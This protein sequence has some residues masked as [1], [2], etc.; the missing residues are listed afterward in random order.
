MN[1]IM[2]CCDTERHKNDTLVGKQSEL[3]AITKIFQRKCNLRRNEQMGFMFC[4]C[5]SVAWIFA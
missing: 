5:Q 1:Y 3:N 2:K 4:C